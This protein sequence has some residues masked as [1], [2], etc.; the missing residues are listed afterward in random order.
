MG[1]FIKILET[2]DGDRLFLYGLG[3][4]IIIIVVMSSIV[5]IVRAICKVIVKLIK[6]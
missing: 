4:I 6:N 3:A 1:E 2:I 5:E